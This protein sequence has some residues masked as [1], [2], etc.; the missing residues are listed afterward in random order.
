LLGIER[1]YGADLSHPHEHKHALYAENEQ[2]LVTPKII[3][4]LMQYPDRFVNDNRQILYIVV[5]PAAIM[6]IQ[7]IPKDARLQRIHGRK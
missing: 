3:Q 2:D 1:Q 5:K 7:T 4:Q 6:E